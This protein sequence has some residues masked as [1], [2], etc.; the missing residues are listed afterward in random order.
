MHP[1]SDIS[2]FFIHHF[3][4]QQTI[5]ISEIIFINTITVNTYYGIPRHAL[6]AL[7]LEQGHVEE[8]QQVYMDDLG[9]TDT[10]VSTSQ[11][12][13]N[14]WSLHGLVECLERLNKRKEARLFRAR[15]NLAIARTDVGINAPVV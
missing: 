11:H 10:L 13:D 3:L 9:L 15:L 12:I 5:I 8:A 4:A 2:N 1:G 14:L 6:G 7:L